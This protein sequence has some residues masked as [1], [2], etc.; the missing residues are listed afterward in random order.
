MIKDKIIGNVSQ[1]L[2]AQITS[3]TEQDLKM[4]VVTIRR[5]INI[6][7]SMTPK[8]FVKQFIILPVGL[9]SKNRIFALRI[10]LVIASCILLELFK[11]KPKITI[12]LIKLAKK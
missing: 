5:T 1:G 10:L 8:S 4:P 6:L 9:V 12:A 7:V 11:I 3:I 2:I